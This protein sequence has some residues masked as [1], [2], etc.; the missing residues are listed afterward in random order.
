[1]YL[2]QQLKSVGGTTT[3]VCRLVQL[4]VS[5]SL[6]GISASTYPWRDG[7]HE[8]SE[9]VIQIAQIALYVC[10]EVYFFDVALNASSLQ[11]YVSVLR[12]LEVLAPPPLE[13]RAFVHASLL[14]AVTWCIYV[15]RDVWPFST[16]NGS[17]ADLAEGKMLWAKIALLSLGGVA[18]P[19]ITPRKYT[20]VNIKVR[21]FAPC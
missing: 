20:P 9:P 8:S 2:G 1:M 6:L 16:S 17:P 18:V 12:L 15:Y 13:H 7:I 21:V 5:L 10:P 3:L 4:L 19:L 11:G 14:L